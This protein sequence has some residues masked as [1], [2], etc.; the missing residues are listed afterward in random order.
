MTPQDQRD[1]L[2]SREQRIVACLQERVPR[3]GQGLKALRARALDLPAMLRRHGLMHVL[4]FLAGKG[5]CD[6]EL[7]DLLHQG[8]AAALADPA[9]AQNVTVYAEGLAV[10]EFPTYLLHWEAAQESATWLKLLVEA[11]TKT[12]PAA[13]GTPAGEGA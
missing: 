4:L 12:V 10:V 6:S 7:A 2:T 5:G 13:M 3:E 1:R 11:R 8:I 9:T